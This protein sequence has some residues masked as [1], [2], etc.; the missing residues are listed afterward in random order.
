MLILRRA[1]GK[2]KLTLL[3]E[4]PSRLLPLGIELLAKAGRASPDLRREAFAA[5]RAPVDRSA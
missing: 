3:V 4:R 2:A 1:Y 5:S